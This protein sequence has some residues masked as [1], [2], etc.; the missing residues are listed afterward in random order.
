[1]SP[2]IKLPPKG[3]TPT[4]EA[5]IESEAM[6]ENQPITAVDES[7]KRLAIVSGKRPTSQI[8]LEAS[9]HEGRKQKK[10]KSDR[11]STEKSGGPNLET[12]IDQAKLFFDTLLAVKEERAR[13][14]SDSVKKSEQLATE[15]AKLKEE[16]KNLDGWKNENKKLKDEVS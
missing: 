9:G 8:D 10:A 6:G 12:A 13:L 11:L 15:S 3:N 5:I 14:I 4:I 16:T 1:M 7:S 2:S